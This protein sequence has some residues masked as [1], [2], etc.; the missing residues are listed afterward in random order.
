MQVE[1]AVVADYANMAENG[2]LNVMGMFDRITAPR[3]PVRHAFMVLALRIR[4][5]W[6]DRDKTHRIQIT[7]EDA[8]GK[9]LGGGEGQ[10]VVGPIPPGE[11]SVLSQILPFAN[12]EFPRAGEYRFRISWD[13]QPKA[14]V[15]LTLRLTTPGPIG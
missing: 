4:V 15:P 14:E 13:G 1:V 2:K 11:R 5:E 6:E 8:D 10:V 3:F 12:I 7:L 9:A